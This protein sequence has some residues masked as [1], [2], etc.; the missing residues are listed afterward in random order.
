MYQ[1][2]FINSGGGGLAQGEADHS[3]RN[4]RNYRKKKARDKKQT[5]I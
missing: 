5:G 2:I 4:D 3:S 1:P